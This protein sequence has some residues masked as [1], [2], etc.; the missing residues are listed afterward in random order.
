MKD[1]FIA[2]PTRFVCAEHSSATTRCKT[3]GLTI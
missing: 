3:I 2:K 1:K